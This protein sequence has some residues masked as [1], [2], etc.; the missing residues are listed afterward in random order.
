M[1]FKYPI[2]NNIANYLETTA[3]ELVASSG[4]S[5]NRNSECAEPAVF[6]VP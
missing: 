2:S 3:S 4:A 6:D 5:Q 1:S